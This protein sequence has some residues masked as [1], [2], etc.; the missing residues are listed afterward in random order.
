M[1]SGLKRF[2]KAESLR[3]VTFRFYRRLPLLEAPGARE[4]VG[5]VPRQNSIRAQDP[6]SKWGFVAKLC[7][8]ST[9]MRHPR[10]FH[11]TNFAKLGYAISGCRTQKVRRKHLCAGQRDL[12]RLWP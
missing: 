8:G 9:G 4:T 5:A 10:A 6:P 7:I 12:V 11:A 3:F 1:P 2:Q